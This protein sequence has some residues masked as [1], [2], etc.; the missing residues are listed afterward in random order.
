[1]GTHF[2]AEE[3][4][5]RPI[6]DSQYLLRQVR[7]HSGPEYVDAIDD[8]F[9]SV[10][11]GADFSVRGTGSW[12]VTFIRERNP[13][14]PEIAYTTARPI[15]LVANKTYALTIFDTS[16][17]FAVDSASALGWVEPVEPVGA[18]EHVLGR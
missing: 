14:G 7:F 1:M 12:Y 11:I 2:A 16:F 3:Q 8:M 6:N 9:E 10:E 13:G 18:G 15:D 4:D 5:R 17:R